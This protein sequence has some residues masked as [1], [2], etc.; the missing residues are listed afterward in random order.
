MKRIYPIDYDKQL[1][2]STPLFKTWTP[3]NEKGRRYSIIQEMDSESATESSDEDTS[4]SVLENTTDMTPIATDS[5][6][7]P[8]STAGDSP[9]PSTSSAI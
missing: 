1:T 8:Q 9:Q 5:T 4:A 2:Y 3:P 7:Q 6:K